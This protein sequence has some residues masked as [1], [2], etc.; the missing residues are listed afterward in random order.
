M[1][2]IPNRHSVFLIVLLLAS[3][4][5]SISCSAVNG[6]SGTPNTSPTSA[7][8]ASPTPQRA[9]ATTALASPTAT[10]TLTTV[11]TF[12]GTNP[13]TT[14]VFDVSTDWNIVWY[15]K[16]FTNPPVP[17]MLIVDIYNADG[18][19][20]YPQVANTACPVEGISDYSG[21]SNGGS[22]YLKISFTG[23]SWTIKIQELK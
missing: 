8:R 23:T 3:I 2:T 13:T 20:A 9:T 16:G 12:T 19:I 11:K 7:S 17:G 1:P 10:L 22:V 14:A 5:L 15:C 4:V 18:T 6:I 21:I